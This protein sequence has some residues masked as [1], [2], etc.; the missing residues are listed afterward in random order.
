MDAAALQAA[1][2]A[3]SADAPA[4]ALYA[5]TPLHGPAHAALRT[6]VLHAMPSDAA[7]AA[8]E[9]FAMLRR[10]DDQGAGEIWIETP[11]STPDWEGVRD[12]LQR[13]AAATAATATVAVS[14]R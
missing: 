10:F 14:A 13:A 9:L 8:A 1:L 11:P 4:L 12:R 2:A 6:V 7:A 5:R 3:R